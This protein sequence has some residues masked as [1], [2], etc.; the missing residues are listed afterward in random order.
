MS[1][2]CHLAKLCKAEASTPANKILNLNARI[3]DNQKIGGS[4]CGSSALKPLGAGAQIDLICGK[5][6]VRF[7][8]PPPRVQA[9]YVSCLQRYQGLRLDP[10]EQKARACIPDGGDQF[11]LPRSGKVY[12]GWVTS[13]H[14]RK[15]KRI[16]STLTTV[17]AMNDNEPVHAGQRVLLAA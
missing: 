13:K 7:P 1:R 14:S 3:V 6:G 10:G 2:S 16:G 12:D 4:Y 8:A 5:T 17:E 9:R 11:R 15:A